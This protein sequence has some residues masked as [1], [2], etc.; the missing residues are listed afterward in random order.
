MRSALIILFAVVTLSAKAQQP[1]DLTG[2][3]YIGTGEAHPTP[4]CEGC[5]NRGSVEF[6]PNAMVDYLLPGSDIMERRTYTRQGALLTLEGGG[7]AIKDE[8]I[9]CM[10]EGRWEV[11][12]SAWDRVL[13]S[14]ELHG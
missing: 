4:G 1:S 8:V 12:V 2:R 9:P 3:R 7:I 14:T 10:S 6:L 5:G 11:G 13:R